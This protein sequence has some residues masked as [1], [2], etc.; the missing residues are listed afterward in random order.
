R[1]RPED[2]ILRTDFHGSFSFPS[3][4]ALLAFFIVGFIVL[5]Y[6]RLK[7]ILIP[8]AICT[9]FSR[10]YCGVHYP[11]DIL[12]GALLGLALAYLYKKLLMNI[13]FSSKL[14]PCF[15]LLTLTTDLYAKD[16]LPWLWEDQ[17][18]P[19]LT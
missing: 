13:K 12:V 17:F 15:L 2:V 19:T 7:K 14:L 3:S 16:F 4:H 6:P 10:I 9:A 8:L 5:F 18:K 11:S 1:D